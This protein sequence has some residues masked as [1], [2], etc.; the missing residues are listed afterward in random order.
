VEDCAQSHGAAIGT[1]K[2]GTWGALSAFSFYPTKNLGALGDAGA[3]FTRDEKLAAKVR[4]LRQYGWRT[5][6]IAESEGRNSRLDEI[7]AAILRVKLPHLEAANARR[8]AIAA[9]YFE[10][11]KGAALILPT[12]REGTLPVYHQ[13]TV[14]LRD[15]DALREALHAKGIQCGVLYPTP[16]HH[17]PAYRDTTLSLPATEQACAEVLCLPCHP[18]LTDADIAEVSA[19]IVAC[20]K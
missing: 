11:L 7:Q 13:F 3:V 5:R 10:K 15:R 6:Y 18:A 20:L 14:R 2:T 16:I 19:A 9:L 8:R 1:R 12:L 17:Q 4:S